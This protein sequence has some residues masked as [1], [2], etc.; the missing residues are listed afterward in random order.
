MPI[1]FTANSDKELK[2][3]DLSEQQILAVVIDAVDDL[4]WDIEAY[5]PKTL[6]AFT[7][8]KIFQSEQKITIN[9]DNNTVT[10]NS[11]SFFIPIMNLGLFFGEKSRNKKNISM[12]TGHIKE[13]LQQTN[14]DELN[15]EYE[16]YS[17]DFNTN[18][19]IDL[20]IE[21]S[22]NKPIPNFRSIFVPR[23]GYYITPILIDFN[24]IIFLLMIYHGVNLFVPENQSLI[25]WGGNLRLLT[26][27][28]GEWW[29]LISCTFVHAGILHLVFNM[30]ALLFIGIL[31]EPY[32]DKLT[33]LLFYV[34]A[35]IGS[36]LNSLYWHNNS[37]S[38]G[39]SG[40]I[41][42]LFGIFLAL[43]SRD[44]FDE[45]TTKNLSKSI[46]FFVIYSLYTGFYGNIDNAGH[47]GGLI[48]GLVIGYVS[49]YSLIN[50]DNKIIKSLT[51]SATI[52]IVFL[53]CL[54][55]Y[56]SMSKSL[57]SGHQ[58]KAIAKLESE[59]LNQNF[60]NCTNRHD[61]IVMLKK[62]IAR[63]RKFV[64]ALESADTINVAKELKEQIIK[65]KLNLKINLNK[66]T[67][68]YNIMQLDTNMKQNAGNHKNDKLKTY[69]EEKKINQ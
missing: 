4:G 62:Y 61:S 22:P 41:F 40:A 45:H 39:A 63:C 6:I 17:K 60:E 28:Q 18:E 3:D 58:M 54:F 9:I 15:S 56:G 65:T 24:I 37:V 26:I 36:S 34:L 5:S 64:T 33:F 44:I 69:L 11:E 7:K 29:R 27:D 52:T 38:V 32:F 55:I 31:L 67:N 21:E 53:F 2:I 14:P 25:D 1:S 35:G 12:L 23:E 57:D 50:P 66:L 43:L 42:G 20:L 16:R 51:I 46:G 19:E 49:Y 48:T 47:I 30:Y 59:A 10:I 8:N 13:L 68:A